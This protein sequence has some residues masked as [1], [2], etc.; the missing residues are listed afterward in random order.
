MGSLRVEPYTT[1]AWW[2]EGGGVTVSEYHLQCEEHAWHA[3]YT[4]WPKREHGPPSDIVRL[5]VSNLI[6]PFN[7]CPCTDACF[8]NVLSRYGGQDAAT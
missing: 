6:G 4:C 3:K 2:K 8:V 7:S 5:L 1:P